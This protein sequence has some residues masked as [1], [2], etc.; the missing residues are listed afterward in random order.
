M[1][2]LNTILIILAFLVF[3]LSITFLLIFFPGSSFVGNTGGNGDNEMEEYEPYVCNKIKKN[4]WVG[5]EPIR[6]EMGMLGCGL[7]TDVEP[8]L[9]EMKNN[10][11][12]HFVK[13]IRYPISYYHWLRNI[14]IGMQPIVDVYPYVLE[15][16]QKYVKINKTNVEFLS[17]DE[18]KSFDIQNIDAMCGCLQ[19]STNDGYIRLYLTKGSP[20]LTFEL[21]NVG[22]IIRSIGDI[23]LDDMVMIVDDEKYLVSMLDDGIRSNNY[24]YNGK[25]RGYY[26]DKNK[27][28]N[29]VRVAKFVTHDEMM[30]LEANKYRYPT[31][32]NVLIDDD[33]VNIKY[34][35]KG[36]IEK[37]SNMI[38]YY[39]GLKEINGNGF[40]MKLDGKVPDILVFFEDI[41]ENDELL[42]KWLSDYN[43]IIDDTRSM[44]FP[45]CVIRMGHIGML[46]M[47][48]EK[49]KGVSI[50]HLRV[51]NDILMREFSFDVLKYDTEW[52][53]I[54]NDMDSENCMGNLYEKFMDIMSYFSVALYVICRESE[55]FHGH[56]ENIIAVFRNFGNCSMEDPYFATWMYKDWYSNRSFATNTAKTINF[57]Y[58]MY[59]ISKIV[60]VVTYMKSFEKLY[61]SEIEYFVENEIDKVD[62]ES[63]ITVM[64]DRK[65]C[66]EYKNKIDDLVWKDYPISWG[67]Y[68][69]FKK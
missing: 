56:F 8:I 50:D 44:Y 9:G 7:F 15:V 32:S 49:I 67:Q 6:R 24:E 54:Y 10:I 29:V 64:M 55:Y 53:M 12:K 51:L 5:V 13:N 63:L 28:P 25:I 58:Y 27:K 69:S 16:Y 20:Y 60:N 2:N 45:S 42:E 1:L 39:D 3:I 30:V 57:Y 21:Y 22:F 23:V 18:I 11:I 37:G 47:L 59:H 35:I 43:H 19:W 38:L 31:Q 4:K 68:F 48:G 66:D 26:F 46:I 36:D 41:I 34:D 17:D 40:L 61:L 52:N 14:I 65:L 33:G 62:L